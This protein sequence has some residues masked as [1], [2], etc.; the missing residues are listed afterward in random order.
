MWLGSGWRAGGL[1]DKLK[2]CLT[3][4][5]AAATGLKKDSESYRSDTDCLSA[6]VTCFAQSHL[7]FVPVL[8]TIDVVSYV[9]TFW[10]NFKL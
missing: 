10:P 7:F 5:N 4:Q 1:W 9:R 8:L 3:N 6:R 2:F